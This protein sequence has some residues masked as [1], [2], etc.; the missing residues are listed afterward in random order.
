MIRALVLACLISLFGG[1]A[2][3]VT[4]PYPSAATPL[5][6]TEVVI[7]WQGGVTKNCTV[8]NLTDQV[9]GPFI[10]LR[11]LSGVFGTLT[12]GVAGPANQNI[13]LSS[14]EATNAASFPDSVIGVCHLT[15]SDIGGATG[16]YYGECSQDHAGICEGAEFD[17]FNSVGAP[18]QSLTGVNRANPT[19]Q[20]LPVA[21]TISA[22]SRAT[23][24]NDSWAG[25]DCESNTAKF[26]VCHYV[27]PAALENPGYGFA[28][29]NKWYVDLNGL[30]Y[31][32]DLYKL[33]GA[34]PA[35]AGRSLLLGKLAS[36]NFNSTS[37]Q[38]I[39]L[40]GTGGYVVSSIIVT[41]C[42]TSITTAQG[43][44]YAA[45]SKSSPLFNT[46]TTTPFTFL[47][48]ATAAATFGGGTT[49]GATSAGSTYTGLA[50][51]YLSLTTPQGGAATCDIYV[52][53]EDLSA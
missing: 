14:S 34:S 19:T 26:F 20:T 7:C 17:T 1:L 41:N 31:T 9:G 15:T 43:A 47:T 27:N 12:M 36:A 23:Y 51:A 3:A 30:E 24:S 35:K 10:D 48:T 21:I 4:P 5:T 16:C 32:S 45:A 11:V 18:Y 46:A 39:A 52:M 29:G 13:L 44:F 40:T 22:G 2:C 25:T 42:S 53:G 33:G 6:G 38:A 37:D 8:T 50:N 28:L 49:T